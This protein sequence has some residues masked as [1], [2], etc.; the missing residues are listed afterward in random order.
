MNDTT[1]AV[2]DSPG[3][4]VETAG[5]F[6]IRNF[7]ATLLGLFG[8]ILTVWGLFFFTPDAAAKTDGLNANLWAGVGMLVFAGSFFLWTRL[9]PLRI[10]VRENEDGA[11]EPRDIAPL[12]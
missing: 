5:A 2:P 10:V 4:Q 1:A 9:E 6:D 12:D 7:I 8:L 3:A 11:E